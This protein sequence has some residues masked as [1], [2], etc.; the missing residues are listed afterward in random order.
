MRYTARTGFESHSC[1]IMG[2][3][4][5]CAEDLV[6]SRVSYGL[7]EVTWHIQVSINLFQSSKLPFRHLESVRRV[8]VSIAIDSLR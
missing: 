5:S 7:A 2:P 8:N 1:R 4:E 3:F 6:W